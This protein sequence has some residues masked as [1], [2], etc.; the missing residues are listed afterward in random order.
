L[1]S[2]PSEKDLE[3]AFPVHLKSFKWNIFRWKVRSAHYGVFR[4]V[5]VKDDTFIV[6][7]S[8]QDFWCSNRAQSLW[9]AFSPV[10]SQD[11][12]NGQVR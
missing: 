4:V 3:G 5:A 7:K 1:H 2:F 8:S 10:R 11:S 12:S 6:T 9:H